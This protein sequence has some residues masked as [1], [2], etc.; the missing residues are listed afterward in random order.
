MSMRDQ[1]TDFGGGFVCGLVSGAAFGLYTGII[2]LMSGN[3]LGLY[4]N[5][6]HSL[7]GTVGGQ[8]EF[9][10]IYIL[11]A[12]ILAAI[13]GVAVGVLYA[14]MRLFLPTK[15]NILKAF[16]VSPFYLV[17]LWAVAFFLTFETHEPLVEQL[18]TANIIVDVIGVII[19]AIMLDLSWNYFGTAEYVVEEKD[20]HRKEN[21]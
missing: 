8:I 3:E 7:R 21:E 5:G 10:I 2:Y 6:I 18:N 20:F 17:I 19:F 9:I 15:S 12:M 16:V 14:E 11:M 1:G 4:F 13:V